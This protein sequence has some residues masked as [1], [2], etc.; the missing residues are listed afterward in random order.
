MYG[1]ASVGNALSG[2][3]RGRDN[4]D[5]SSR[6]ATEGVPYRR[7]AMSAYANTF[8]KMSLS[9]RIF[10]SCP[11]NSISVPEYLP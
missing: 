5:R 10:T 9:R 8:A 7:W 6:N 3:P 4:L 1:F 11:F 2:V